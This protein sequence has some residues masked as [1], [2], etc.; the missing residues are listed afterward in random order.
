[1]NKNIKMYFWNMKSEMTFVECI[2]WQKVPLSQ[3]TS[4]KIA[5]VKIQPL[6]AIIQ[7]NFLFTKP[8]LGWHNYAKILYATI[9]NWNIIFR[10]YIH[11]I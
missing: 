9:E 7:A 10:V 3:I 5:D 6:I 4:Q 1:M 8:L 11:R 2:T